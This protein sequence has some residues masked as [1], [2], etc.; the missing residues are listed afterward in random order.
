MENQINL[1]GTEKQ[2]KWGKDLLKNTFLFIQEI[3]NLKFEE[4]GYS[5]PAKFEYAKET[6]QLVWDELK[7]ESA[8]WI[9]SNR[10]SINGFISLKYEEMREQGFERKR[11]F[12]R[13]L[14]SIR[15]KL[16]ENGGN[17]N[18]L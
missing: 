18:E 10:H 7:N 13:L 17:A 12:G 11:T 2:V 4:S 6:I 14:L 5:D 3:E 8:S 9:I 15:E 16:I 1:Q